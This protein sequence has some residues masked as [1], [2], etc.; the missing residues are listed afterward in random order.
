MRQHRLHNIFEPTSIAFVGATDRVGSV[1]ARVMSN[2]VAAGFKGQLYPVNPRRDSLLG[3]PCYSSLAAIDAPIDLVVIVIPSELIAGVLRECVELRV[4]GVVIMSSG[5]GEVGPLAHELQKELVTLARGAGIPLIGPNCL[6]VVRPSAGLNTTYSSSPVLPGRVAMVSQSGAFC[7]SIMDA[8]VSNGRGFSAI[9]SLGATADVGFGQVL[10]YLSTDGQTNSVLLYIERIVN[11]RS[12]LSGLRAAAR[13]KPVIVLKPGRHE[14]GRRAAISHTGGYSGSD[15]VFNAALER[16]GAV[17]VVTAS[18]LMAAANILSSKTRVRGN[19]LAIVTNGGGPGVMATDHAYEHDVPLAQMEPETLE[20]LKNLLP[21]N[22]HFNGPVD[23]L[24]DADPERYEQALGIVLAD[25]N[26]DG[27]LVLLTPQAMTDASACADAVIRVAKN[28]FKPVLAGWLGQNLVQAGRDRLEAAGIPTF[29]NPEAGVDGFGYLTAYR[30]NQERLLQAP[31]PLSRQRAPD[32][33]RARQIL[34]AVAA[35]GRLSLNNVESR[36]LVECFHVPVLGCNNANTAEEAQAA[37]EVLGLPVVMKI[38]SPDIAHKSA[39]GGVRLNVRE[40]DSVPVIYREMLAEVAFRAPEARIHGITLESME[41]RPN[42]REVLVAIERDPVFGPVIRFGSGG[43]SSDVYADSRVALPPLNV[44]LCKDLIH[45]T[46]ASR[47]L[48][49]FRNLP[50]VDMDSLIDILMRASEMACELPQLERLIINPILVDESGAVAVDVWVKMIDQPY[51]GARYGHL[52]IH[53]YPPGLEFS[54]ITK[55]GTPLRVR[56]IRPE[57]A[58]LERRFAD[59]LSAQSKY[60]RFM[61]GV[62]SFSAAMIARFTQIDYDREMALVAV[63][64]DETPQAR[65]Q[66]VARYVANPGGDSCEF[67]LTVADAMHQ[68][69]VGSRMME[70]LMTIARHRGFKEMDGDVLAQNHNMLRLV[71]KLGFKVSRNPLDP[72]VMRVWRPLR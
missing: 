21:A 23:L 48:R 52:A 25:K 38:N 11:P 66:S 8:A 49:G 71:R 3:Q 44:F 18:E 41:D 65:L 22:W 37:A 50:D 10:D 59:D 19:R 55:N 42:A 16:A 54:L 6:G 63:Q 34:E 9:L 15:E 33:V 36:A 60:N 58:E 61:Y 13:L 62:S 28:S 43:L 64:D 69:G 12:F 5:F 14:T 17:R 70:Q 29:A 45:R 53:P 26:V 31:S 67:A 46:R 32:I 68:Q 27:V 4:G 1:G 51:K 57:D 72:D 30:R 24:G 56:P 2:L 47:A 40:A 7:T 35:E 20:A 39:V